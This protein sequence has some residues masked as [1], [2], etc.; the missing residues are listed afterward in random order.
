[1]EV[2][3]KSLRLLALIASATAVP[4][5]AAAEEVSQI[6][7]QL[8][9]VGQHNDY[10]YSFRRWNISSN[11]IGWMLGSYGLSVSYAPHDNF[12][13]RAD[14]NYFHPVG[15]HENGYELGVGVPI[16]FRRSYQG[17]FLEPG[18]IVRHTET[19]YDT[20]ASKTIF[21]PQVLVGWHW[22]WDSGLN[23]AAA[24]GVGRNWS[25]KPNEYDDS[26]DEPFVNG[27]LRFGY[28]F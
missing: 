8:V 5:A 18:L 16:Y 7:G 26:E 11:P 6:Q 24:V 25:T 20:S 13:L 12:A 17:A 28:A 14:V 2:S 9:P 22:T 27:Y 1:M 23:I 3:M 15:S 21:G 4:A 10:L 19:D